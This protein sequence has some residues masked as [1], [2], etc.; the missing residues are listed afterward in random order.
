[1]KATENRRRAVGCDHGQRNSSIPSGH[2]RHRLAH[3]SRADCNNLPG[4][5]TSGAPRPSFADLDAGVTGFDTLYVA[6]EGGT[7]QKFSL[8]GGNGCRW[9]DSPYRRSR[10]NRHPYW[11]NCH[12]ICHQHQ[13]PCGH[14]RY[15]RLQCC[16]CSHPK[17]TGHCRCQHCL[18][19]GRF[20]AR[21]I[22]HRCEGLEL[23]LTP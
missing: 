23:I 20:C 7:V 10:L 9:Y 2:S 18:S 21:Y 3:C 5:P 11:R 6:D 19:R 8:A 12:A 14:C 1:M 4:F 22:T 16:A 15:F 13:Q 17:C